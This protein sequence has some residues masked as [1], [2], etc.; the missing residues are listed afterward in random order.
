MESKFFNQTEIGNLRYDDLIDCWE[1]IKDVKRTS[2]PK[3]SRALN[4][5]YRTVWRACNTL[6][7]LG[8]IERNQKKIGLTKIITL[9]EN[10]K[11]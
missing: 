1:Y 2:A 10:V 3:M 7:I 8:L 4:K 5:N 9:K 6:E 11:I